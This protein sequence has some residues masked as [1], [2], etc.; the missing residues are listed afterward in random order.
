MQPQASSPFPSTGSAQRPLE[1]SFVR[2]VIVGVV[3]RAMKGLVAP[4]AWQAFLGS[5][6]PQARELF[7]RE[8]G[9]YEWVPMP[10][11][12]EVSRRFP[13]AT[14]CDTVALRGGLYADQ[15]LTRSHQWM[16]KVMTPELLIR[17]APKI[18]AFYHQGGQGWTEDVAPGRAC[19]LLRAI[20]PSP[21]WAEIL[22]PSWL[23][24]ALEL[25]G[26]REVQVVY[27]PPMD[28]ADPHLHRFWASW[29]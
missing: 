20:G 16:L 15:M 12:A 27:E 26:A 8:M 11:L 18:F 5:L 13:A 10:L 23:K 3:Q 2:G 9:D 21:G 14:G 4:E 29:A 19:L 22:L 24:R 17:Q 28:P 6:S 7:S 1:V 25:T